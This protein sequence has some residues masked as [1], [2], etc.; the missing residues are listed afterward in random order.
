ME[1]EVLK[2]ITRFSFFS[3]VGGYFGKKNF[4]RRLYIEDGT[5]NSGKRK[6]F[7]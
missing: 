6:S 7:D 4:Y 5:E 2:S 3:E 1:E